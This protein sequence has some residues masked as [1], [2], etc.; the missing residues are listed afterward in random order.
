MFGIDPDVL[1][2]PIQSARKDLADFKK[3]LQKSTESRKAKTNRWIGRARK[4]D[5]C[6]QRVMGKVDYQ[7]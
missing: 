2:M 5:E 7:L 1:M 4:G 6:E 3:G